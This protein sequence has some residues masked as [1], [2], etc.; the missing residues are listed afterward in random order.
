MPLYQEYIRLYFNKN[1]NLYRKEYIYYMI[2]CPIVE[3]AQLGG[4]GII[5]GEFFNDK[6]WSE[7]VKETSEIFFQNNNEENSKELAIQYTEYVNLRNQL[8]YFMNS[9][10][11]IANNWNDYVVKAIINTANIETEN[12]MFGTKIKTDSKLIRVFCPSILDDGFRTNPSELFWVI[13]INPLV[14]E[15]KR[16]HSS[17]SWEKELND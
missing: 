10:D 15:E 16:F 13:C 11:L 8:R 1:K 12:T 9:R 3:W 4:L 7:I 2:T 17:F 5:W 14:P 6:E